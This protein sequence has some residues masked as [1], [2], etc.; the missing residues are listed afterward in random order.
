MTEVPV[1]LK[2][3]HPPVCFDW[4]T[5]FRAGLPFFLGDMTLRLVPKFFLM[6][7]DSRWPLPPNLTYSEYPVTPEAALRFLQ[8]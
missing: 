6:D 5:L 4:R 3:C 2:M 7:L 1:S 8:D